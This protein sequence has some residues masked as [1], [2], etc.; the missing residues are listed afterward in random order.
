MLSKLQNGQRSVDRRTRMIFTYGAPL[1]AI[2][3]A[4]PL[5][6]RTSKALLICCNCQLKLIYYAPRG[7]MCS[8]CGEALNGSRLLC[9]DCTT[10]GLSQ[11]FDLCATCCFSTCSRKKDDKYHTN[12]HTLL[13][14][15]SPPLRMEH[16]SD[17][18]WAKQVVRF[19]RKAWCNGCG[20]V[21]S[22]KPYWRCMMCIGGCIWYI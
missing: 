1:L 18:A 6:T 12:A 7:L 11:S 4:V 10:G 21:L 9:C 14:L 2:N 20:N 5:V 19:D 13:Q 16:I 22:D 8:N 17:F 15:R 3:S